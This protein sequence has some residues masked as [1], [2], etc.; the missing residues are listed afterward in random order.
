MHWETE[1]IPSVWKIQRSKTISSWGKYYAGSFWRDVID[2]LT[3]DQVD[4]QQSNP[5]LTRW[6][7]YT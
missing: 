6:P 1:E 3:D 4:V 5:I 2:K 7:Y